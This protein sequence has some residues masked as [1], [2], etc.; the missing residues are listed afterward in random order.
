MSSKV[1]KLVPVNFGGVGRRVVTIQDLC[2][3]YVSIFPGANTGGGNLTTHKHA[4]QLAKGEKLLTYQIDELDSVLSFR[5]ELMKL[6][7]EYKNIFGLENI[8]CHEFDFETWIRDKR[9]SNL[10]DK[11]E[12]YRNLVFTEDIFPDP[13]PTQGHSY[14]KPYNYLAAASMDSGLG[15]KATQEAIVKIL[16]CMF[17][18]IIY[19]ILSPNPLMSR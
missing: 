14:A 8:D 5:M 1:R 9:V 4:V 16:A 6:V 3:T 10:Q 11:C 15:P 19:V 2:R 18:F 13:S 17:S 12:D 7:T